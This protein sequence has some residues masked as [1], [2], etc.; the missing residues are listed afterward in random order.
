MSSEDEAGEEEEG[1]G[2]MEE[3]ETGR[4]EEMDVGEA[5]AE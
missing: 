3:F 1:K 2:E 4:E 5:V